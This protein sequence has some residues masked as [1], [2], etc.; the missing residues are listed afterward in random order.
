MDIKD[1]CKH[2][3]LEIRREG[4]HHHCTQGYIQFDC[5][6]CSPKSGR[7]RL[8]WNLEGH[9]FSCWQCGHL[10]VLETWHRLSRVP[11]GELVRC[12]KDITHAY[13]YKERKLPGKL[14]IPKGLGPL[15][16]PHLKYLI[17]RGFRNIKDMIEKWQ[18][19]AFDHTNPRLAWRIFIPVIYDGEVVSW[20]TRSI[21]DKQS[22][23]YITAGPGEQMFSIKSLLFGADHCTNTVIVTE[24]PMDAMKLG[25]GAVAL[26]GMTWTRSQLLAIS[27]FPKRY[28]VFDG[29]HEATQRSKTLATELSVFPGSTAWIGL[30]PGEDPASLPKEKLQDLRKLL[31]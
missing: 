3:S 12:L 16:T 2:L 7:F 6:N 13:N 4:E 11:R 1:F 19:Q 20:T 14:V 10:P 15:Q 22:N 26:C 29:G 27:K 8:G 31:D 9:F 30:K 5:P 18:L 17:N 28:I 25:P 24:G 21:S 23:R